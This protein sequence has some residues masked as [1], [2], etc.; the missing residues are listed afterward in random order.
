MRLCTFL[1]NRKTITKYHLYTPNHLYI[2][3]LCGL[4]KFG[5]YMAYGI[6]SQ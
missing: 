5:K 4:N 1:L 2:Q 3:V 6:F